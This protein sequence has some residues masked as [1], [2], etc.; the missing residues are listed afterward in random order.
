MA[1]RWVMASRSSSGRA[2]SWPRMVSSGVLKGAGSNN[3]LGQPVP[4]NLEWP[5]PEFPPGIFSI[6]RKEDDLGA[7]YEVLHRHE[8]DPIHEATVGGIVAIVAHG[9]HMV[10]RYHVFRRVV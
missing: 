7:T 1:E 5:P 3:A 10:G 8:P 2:K 4:A 6:D 9:K